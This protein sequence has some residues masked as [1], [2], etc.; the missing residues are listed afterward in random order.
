MRALRWLPAAVMAVVV[1]HP[2]GARVVQAKVPP[3]SS[4]HAVPPSQAPAVTA[5]LPATF[6][7]P[8]TTP[9]PGGGH[10]LV[11]GEFVQVVHADGHVTSVDR[12]AADAFWRPG[13]GM[14]VKPFNS[15]SAR[16]FAWVGGRWRQTGTWRIGPDYYARLSP[17][18]RWMAYS[19]FRHQHQTNAVQ[20]Q[21]LHGHVVRFPLPGYVAVSW[22]P[23][24]RVVLDRAGNLITWDPSSGAIRQFMTVEALSEVLDAPSGTTAWLEDGQGLSWSAD[25]RYFAVGAQ[26]GQGRRNHEA[27]LIGEAG[28][29]IV[30]VVATSDWF[31]FPTWSPVRDEIAYLQTS[32]HGRRRRLYVVDARTGA[33][34]LVRAQIP[35]VTWVAWSPEGTWLLLPEHTMKVR[36][37]LFVSRW[38]G[39]TIEYPYLGDIPRWAS[40]G[41]DVLMPVC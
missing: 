39:R 19:P 22:T 2:S 28:G 37:W 3:K 26:W 9:I 24:G 33:R 32:D 17:D 16:Q 29:R 1:C 15:N 34:T 35:D 8:S 18:G 4:T 5:A 40:P 23:D 25:G 14:V 30:R 41:A 13:G 12:N 38:S 21:D 7:A 36:R 10:I 6:E 11:A 20:I 27:V 31:G